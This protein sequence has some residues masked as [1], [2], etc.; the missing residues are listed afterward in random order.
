MFKLSHAVLGLLLFLPGSLS[1][2]EDN[3]KALVKIFTS[4]LKSDFARP[5]NSG[6]QRRS[7]GSG[8]V[9]IMTRSSG[10]FLSAHCYMRL[11]RTMQRLPPLR[12]CC[13]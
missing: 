11:T 6:S 10:C 13:K 5:W 1:A 8:C 3:T 12:R 4:K 9:V 2:A 7:G